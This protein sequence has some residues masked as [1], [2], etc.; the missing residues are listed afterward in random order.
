[1]GVGGERQ[2][3]SGVAQ[4]EPGFEEM[5]LYPINIDVACMTGN[6]QSF[7]IRDESHC[8]GDVDLSDIDD[9]GLPGN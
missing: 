3:K 7:Y 1:M 4:F 5:D 8:G 9:T 6:C 2:P